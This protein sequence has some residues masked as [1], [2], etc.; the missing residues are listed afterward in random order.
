[1]DL[2]RKAMNICIKWKND[3]RDNASERI[4]QR[5]LY[6]NFTIISNNC[7]GG[8]V[9]RYFGL[10][11]SSPTVGLFF[12]AED[13][14]RFVS[15]LKFYM[16]EDLFFISPYATHRA[17]EV[18]GYVD[19]FGK[20]PIGRIK[21]VDIHFLHYENEKEAYEKWNKRKERMDWSRIIVKMSQQN[22]WSDEIVHKFDDLSLPNKLFFE[23][24][25]FY[26]NNTTEILFR[27][28]KGLQ[29]TRNEGEVYRR[30][31]NILKYINS[32]ENTLEY[33]QKMR[34]KLPGEGMG[35]L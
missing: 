33:F 22:L 16:S 26:L 5:L 15:D 35:I 19:M 10:P 9:Y 8:W 21:D 31:I 34:F 14:L 30:Y 6:P 32:S 28:D 23:T 11:Y 1:M 2:V 18:A 24:K 17:D 29:N 27:R 12:L 25:K 3:K 20:Y 4:K 7:W 13:Y